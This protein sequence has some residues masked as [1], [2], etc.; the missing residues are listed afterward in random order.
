[1]GL[2]TFGKKRAAQNAP[3]IVVSGL[4]RSGTSMLMKMLEAGGLAL[5]TDGIR[6]ADNDNP[7]GYYEFERVKKL[8]TD[9]AWLPQAEGK[10]VKVI[11]MLL[12]HLPPEYAYKVIF[13]RRNIGEV[14][15]SQKRMLIRRGEPTDKVSDD[16]MT[17]MYENHLHQVATWLDRQKG[18]EVLQVNYNRIL[19]D[20]HGCSQQINRFIGG[21]LDEQLMAGVVDSTLYR[22][23]K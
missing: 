10:G 9:K 3:I 18:F 8:E 5:L 13:A 22:Q 20:P 4:P 6:T 21:H 15:A 2:F 11:S 14:L 12:Q 19:K 23:R 7:R 16:E 17:R 1:M